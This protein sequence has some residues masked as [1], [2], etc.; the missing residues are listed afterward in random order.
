[1]QRGGAM[2]LAIAAPTPHLLAGLFLAAR[3]R[4]LWTYALFNLENLL[5]LAQPYCLGLAISGL[6]SGAHGGL[7]WLA[8][9]HV[10]WAAVGAVRRA[11]DTRTFTGLYTELAARVVLEQRRRDVAVSSIAA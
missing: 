7:A 6:L 10:G 5:L 4:I 8:A 3:R 2:S 9:Q 11:Y 1:M